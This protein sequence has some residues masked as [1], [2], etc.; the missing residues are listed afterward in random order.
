MLRR[1]VLLVLTRTR[2]LHNKQSV[3]DVL[4]KTPTKVRWLLLVVAQ[5]TPGRAHRP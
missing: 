4:A 5:T 3:N 2:A 1:S